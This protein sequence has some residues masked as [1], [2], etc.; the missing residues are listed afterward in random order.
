MQIGVVLFLFGKSLWAHRLDRGDFSGRFAL[1]AGDCGRFS[2]RRRHNLVVGR[3][4]GCAGCRWPRAILV[5]LCGSTAPGVVRVQGYIER[6]I[7][8]IK[9]RDID[10]DIGLINRD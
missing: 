8:E 7:W 4:L 2:L 5:C 10:D 9:V 1:H 6:R 3:G